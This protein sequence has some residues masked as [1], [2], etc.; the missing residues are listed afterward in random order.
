M[1]RVKKGELKEKERTRWIEKDREEIERN[2][3]KQFHILPILTIIEIKDIA[4]CLIKM[5]K[6]NYSNHFIRNKN[7]KN[8]I[9]N[10]NN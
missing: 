8:G 10:I 1:G 3:S 9:L 5:N 7:N 4:M 2:K 6:K